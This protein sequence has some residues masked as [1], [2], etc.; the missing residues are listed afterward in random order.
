MSRTTHTPHAAV[1]RASSVDVDTP[2]GTLRIVA[3]DVAVVAIHFDPDAAPQFAARRIGDLAAAD[4]GT[5]ADRLLA[6]VV[7]ELGEYFAGQ[8][9]RFT[10]PVAPEGTEFQ[11]A[12]WRALGEIPFGATR[13]YA[14]QAA[15]LGDRRKARAVGA[16]N[17]KNPIPIVVPCHRVVGADGSLTGF[18]G[19]VEVKR[20]LLDHER[21]TIGGW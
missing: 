5:P 18:A 19:G 13:S 15:R 20:W 17:G 8:R 10:V 12:A 4:D 1:R 11:L 3:T 16:A 7:G 21:R 9:Q 2:I 6:R 14:E